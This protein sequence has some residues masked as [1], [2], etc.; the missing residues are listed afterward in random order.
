MNADATE[1][2]SAQARSRADSRTSAIGRAQSATLGQ[3]RALA[4]GA[5]LTT[6]ALGAAR[7]ASA[8]ETGNGSP[9]S[10]PRPFK[11]TFDVEWHGMGAGTSTLQLTRESATDYTYRSSNIARGL[12]RLAIPDTI[13]QT[14][15][16]SVVDGKVRPSSYI[17]DD[18]SGDTER[19][20]SLNFD[21]T[22]NRVTGTAENKPVNQ[23][24]SPGVQDSLSVQ[25]ALMCALAAGQSPK[26]FQ[27]IDKDEVKEYQYTHEGNATLDTPA[28]KLET[29]IYTS[30]RKGASRLTRL[31]IAPSLGYLPVRAEQVRKGK[32]ELQL[33]LQAVERS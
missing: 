9:A 10:C 29:V 17:G 25:V 1:H 4:V 8:A 16:I 5:M 20:V 2:G 31:W 24:I 32:R 26:S 19:D 3:L 6:L 23:P 28:G 13:T 21:W 33:T 27:L 7:E 15:R 11:V 12:F 22:A 30:Q 14:S 18:G